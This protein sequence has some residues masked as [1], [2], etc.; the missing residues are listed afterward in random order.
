MLLQLYGVY[1]FAL[2]RYK[3]TH[4]QHAINV[5]HNSHEHVAQSQTHKS[6]Q[7]ASYS[8]TQ[9]FATVVKCADNRIT[10]VFPN[11]ATNLFAT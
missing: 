9:Y 6:S 7:H 10:Y 5:A 3:I 8:E 1:V 2:P 4:F 11:A